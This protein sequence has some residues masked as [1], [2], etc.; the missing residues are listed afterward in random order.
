MNIPH[1][2]NKE[3]KMELLKYKLPWSGHQENHFGF[4]CCPWGGGSVT[5]FFRPSPQDR[6][7]Y[8]CCPAPLFPSRT[9]NGLCVWVRRNGH[10]RSACPLTAA[11]AAAAAAALCQGA[12]VGAISISHRWLWR[13]T[14]I[15]SVMCIQIYDRVGRNEMWWP[16]SDLSFASSTFS[17]K[18]MP[19]KQ[20][21]HLASIIS[22]TGIVSDDSA[23]IMGRASVQRI[24]NYS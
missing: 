12:G 1:R 20:P 17:D 11:A 13:I 8:L 7:V 14:T 6:C 21:H 18:N 2:Y 4:Q 19:L 15:C 9:F 5:V 22:C 3:I 10:G 16:C 23:Q 24:E